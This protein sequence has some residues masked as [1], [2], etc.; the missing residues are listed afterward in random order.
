MGIFSRIL[1]AFSH[2]ESAKQA[3]FASERE[4]SR[5][6]EGRPEVVAELADWE[7]TTGDGIV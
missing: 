2:R 3:A 5:I 4:A 1:A 6:D 7:T